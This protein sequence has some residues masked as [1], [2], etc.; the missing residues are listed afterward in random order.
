M[1]VS[2]VKFP[3]KFHTVVF[4][5]CKVPNSASSF[6]LLLML[7][8]IRSGRLAEIWWSICISKSQRS[9]C[10]SFFRIDSGLCSYHSFVWSNFNFLLNWQWITL[11]TKL[12]LVLYSFCANLLHLLIMWLIISSL[13]P[14][15]LH[16]LFCCVFSILTLVSPCDVVLSCCLKKFSFYLKVSFS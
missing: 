10:V 7:I 16:L 3:S 15:S 1:F 2:F 13:S 8:I 4:R 14:H 9:M 5:D 12:C 11:P 6:F